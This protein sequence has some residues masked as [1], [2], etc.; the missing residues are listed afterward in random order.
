M[1]RISS[2]RTQEPGNGLRAICARAYAKSPGMRWET[3]TASSQMQN[4]DIWFKTGARSTSC[5]SSLITA[6]PT[7]NTPQIH[8]SFSCWMSCAMQLILSFVTWDTYPQ[9][10]LPACHGIILVITW[11]D[12]IIVNIQITFT[13]LACISDRINRITRQTN[14]CQLIPLLAKLNKILLSLKNNK[15]LPISYLLSSRVKLA[16]Q[17]LVQM[18]YCSHLIVCHIEHIGQQVT[19]CYQ[20]TPKDI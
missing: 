19:T 20:W 15:N 4:W 10:L 12:L 3:L 2:P 9:F 16:W 13:T 17:S 18:S 11:I 8:C 6:Y 14:R 5:K 1:E 7:I